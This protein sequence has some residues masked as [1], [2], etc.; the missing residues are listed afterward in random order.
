MRNVIREFIDR[1]P[2]AEC[3]NFTKH[4]FYAYD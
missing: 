2:L 4:C 1:F 3:G